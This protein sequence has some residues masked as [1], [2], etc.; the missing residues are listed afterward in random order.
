MKISFGMCY[1][2]W[3]HQPKGQSKRKIFGVA[4]SS[5]PG[6]HTTYTAI[7]SSK[8]IIHTNFLILFYMVGSKRSPHLII[9]QQSSW[10]ALNGLIFDDFVPFNIRK[11]WVRPF[12]EFL[13]EISKKFTSTIFSLYNPKGGPF[14]TCKNAWIFGSFLGSKKVI[15]QL[16]MHK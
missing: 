3:T 10:N 12:L 5:W 6:F 16:Q 7:F 1:E 11:V 15:I 2:F 4:K 13:F 14:Y 9:V 8:Y